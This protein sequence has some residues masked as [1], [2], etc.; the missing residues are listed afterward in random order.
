MIAP[1]ASIDPTIIRQQIERALI[2]VQN[3][4]RS[5]TPCRK[6]TSNSQ[7]LPEERAKLKSLRGTTYCTPSLWLNST[8]FP[9]LPKENLLSLLNRDV[10]CVILSHID[11]Q[12]FC[13]YATVNKIWCEF[14][15]RAALLLRSSSS[16]RDKYEMPL[17][18]GTSYLTKD[19]ILHMNFTQAAYETIKAALD[20]RPEEYEVEFKVYRY[21][22][23]MGSYISDSENPT[24]GIQIIGADLGLGD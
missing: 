21:D 16:I 20:P 23:V 9:P 7:V 13:C 14:A 22:S 12:S 11:L 19:G 2:N 15:K 18:A 10:E 24:P 8:D 6:R 3:R 1:V 5:R 4:K 17:C